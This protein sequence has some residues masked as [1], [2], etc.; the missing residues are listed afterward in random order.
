MRQKCCKMRVLHI[1]N[2]FCRSKV[3]ANLCQALDELGV[4]Q[5]VYCPVRNE[6]HLGKNRFEGNSISFVY[7]YCIRPWY[8]YVYH[9]KKW[10]LYR[11][12]KK[13]IDLSQFDVI[14]A[15]TLFSDGG[16][17]YKAY[18]EYGIPYIV[19]VRSTDIAFIS[20]LEHTYSDGRK[21]LLNASRII[22]ISAATFQKFKQ[23]RFACPILSEMADKTEL[24]P[25]GIDDFWIQHISHEQHSGLQVLYVGDFLPRK[26]VCRLIEAVGQVRTIKGYNDT[27]LI[28]VGGGHDK[29]NQT[30]RCI[31]EHTDFVESLGRI[32]DKERLRN[33]MSQCSLFAM[34]SIHET[35]G[36]VYL[37]A[38][39]QNLPVIYTKDDG[40]DGLFDETVGIGV[41]PISVEDIKM[42]II[43]ILSHPHRYSNQHIDFEQFR[44]TT[45]ARRYFSLYQKLLA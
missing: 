9:Y 34:P 7:S 33:M 13:R 23:T 43:K 40:I 41:N 1:S 16:L 2:G 3:H 28:I 4:E 20:R 26:N 32:D 19:A 17:A 18:R 5:T 25:N 15:A 10:K 27:K 14:H 6:A 21:I 31:M 29:K 11:D 12:M 38:L 42:G 24:Q 45:I 30:E 44:W 22:F 37:E 39:S 8:K 36:L 35:F